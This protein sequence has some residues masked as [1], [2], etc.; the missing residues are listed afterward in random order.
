[1]NC[2]VLILFRFLM[3]FFLFSV[4]CCADSDPDIGRVYRF[5]KTTT[6]DGRARTYLLNLPPDYYND[7]SSFPLVVGLHGTGGSASQFDR[8]YGLTQKANDSGFIVV[9]PEGVQSNGI[10]GVR[11]WNAGTCCDYA[12]E[13]N[14]DDVKFILGLIDKLVATY[15]VNPK[16]IYVTGMS[17][18]GMMAYRLAC[19]AA[20][21]IAALAAVSSTMVASQ[22]CHPSR[23]VPILHIHSVL[24]TK[25]P[26]N[27]GIGIGGYYFPPVD[28][29]L[30]VWSSENSCAAPEVTVDNGEYK[31]TKWL[32]C[33]DG[34]TIEL[35]LTQDGGHA[36]PG[37]L[38]SGVWGD[39]P[40]VTVNATDLLWEFFQRFEL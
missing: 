35:Y 11:T 39:T 12:R 22:P 37:G 2:S 27:G 10:L 19:E 13:N 20:D 24:D 5:Q 3:V 26:Y 32:S 23:P 4:V 25:V 8:D 28:S 9:Y 16:R 36:W 14:V 15:R 1:M 34:V 18:G 33:K 40:S 21:K 29:I 30:N 31:L 6:V 7:S 38:R 17:N